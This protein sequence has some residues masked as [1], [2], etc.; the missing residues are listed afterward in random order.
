[1]GVAKDVDPRALIE[2]P[3]I[4]KAIDTLGTLA[5]EMMG[6]EAGGQLVSMGLDVL[7]QAE[8]GNVR[9]AVMQG[10]DLANLVADTI[11]A[12]A[13]TPSGRERTRELAPGLRKAVA[14]VGPKVAALC[15]AFRWASE[16]DAVLDAS[17]R[18][19]EATGPWGGEDPQA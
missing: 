12:G 15:S 2:R 4:A 13:Q 3:D 19:M 7:T 8:R 14:T 16:Y 9:A 17:A 10:A 1:M 5:S 18:I 6:P 11:Q